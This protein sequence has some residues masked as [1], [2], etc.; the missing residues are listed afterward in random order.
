MIRPIIEINEALC[1]GCGACVISCAEGAIQII[2]GKAK[3][4]KDEF[5]DGMGAC[6]GTCP[7]GALKIVERDAPQF[8]EAAAMDHV[9]RQQQIPVSVAK[10]VTLDSLP[11]VHTGCPGSRTRVQGGAAKK[12]PVVP[13]TG[14][15]AKVNASDLG[16][17]PVQLHLVPT[18]AA[19]FEGKELVIMS[20]CAP[21]ASADVHWRFL[22]GRAVVVA[23]PKLDRTDSYVDKLARIFESNSIPKILIVR[24]TVPC[25][26]GLTHMVQQALSQCSRPVEVQEVIVD[27]SGDILQ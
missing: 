7:R 11:L 27:V 9:N 21:L 3:V 5:C 4:M 19:F 22:R 26:G 6:I 25:C 2:D 24:M 1:D 23:C 8:D 10:K 17:W 14:L 16:Q 20:T 18:R 15:P 13:T 12:P